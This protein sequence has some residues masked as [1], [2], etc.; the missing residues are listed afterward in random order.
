MYSSTSYIGMEQQFQNV[1]LINSFLAH[2]NTEQYT[3]NATM[4]SCFPQIDSIDEVSLNVHD[5]GLCAPDTC[6]THPEE[7]VILLQSN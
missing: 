3:S 7:I 5:Q 1:I 2:K 4:C 6:M